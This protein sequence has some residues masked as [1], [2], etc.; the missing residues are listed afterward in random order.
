MEAH[1]LP[2]AVAAVLEEKAMEGAVP[3][4]APAPG[5]SSA[6]VSSFS[7]GGGAEKAAIEL[8]LNAEI[9]VYG[10]AQ[11]GQTLRVN[12]RPVTINDDGTF[13]VRWALP[14]AKP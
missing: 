12:G 7:M 10:R 6:T 9:V 14:V 4:V 11:P 8:E 13:H 3:A 5:C 1:E 2:A